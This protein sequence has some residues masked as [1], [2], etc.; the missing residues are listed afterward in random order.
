MDSSAIGFKTLP[1]AVGTNYTKIKPDIGGAKPSNLREK[2]E[3]VTK[4]YEEENHR[5]ACEQKKLR[6]EKDILDREMAAKNT[7]YIFFVCSL[8][9]AYINYS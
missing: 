5:R 2:F 4:L 8:N 6:E 3:N 7:V 9:N 1:D